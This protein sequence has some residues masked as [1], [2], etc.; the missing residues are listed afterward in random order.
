MCLLEAWISG[1]L[2]IY[3]I[4]FFS[5]TALLPSLLLFRQCCLYFTLSLSLYLFSTYN[6]TLRL[7]LLCRVHSIWFGLDSSTF[8]TSPFFV[9]NNIPRVTQCNCALGYRQGVL[10]LLSS[11]QTTRGH[12]ENF[13]RT[14]VR[15]KTLNLPWRLATIPLGKTW[16]E[17][18]FDFFL[19][20]MQALLVTHLS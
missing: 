3:F 5:D 18:C 2:C 6:D 7:S 1:V 8:I 13:P 10:L 15:R 14:L 12:V 9:L 17:L 11:Y 20:T 16:E 19:H 4:F